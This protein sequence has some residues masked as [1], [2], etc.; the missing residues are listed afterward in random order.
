MRP[1]LPIRRIPLLRPFRPPN[2]PTLRPFTRNTLA[3]PNLPYLSDSSRRPTA[4]FLTIETKQWLKSEVKKGMKYTAYIYTFVFLGLIIT[5]GVYQET[6]ERQYHPPPEWGWYT[7]YHWKMAM[8]AEDPENETQAFVDYANTGSIYKL[9]IERLEDPNNEGA[10][11]QEQGEGGILV[12]GVGRTGFDI[13]NKSESWRRGYYGA[14]MG[15]ARA[16]EHLDDCVKDCQRMLVFPKS[17]VPGPSNP[18]PRPIPPGA[19]TPSREEDCEK[20]FEPPEI[21]YMRILTTKG[22]TEKQRVDTALAYGAWLDFKG[23]HNTALEMYKWAMEIA[24]SSS[25]STKPVIDTSIWT[26]DPNAGPPSANVLSVATAIA[27]HHALCSN[28]AL[29]LPIFISI[30]RSRRSLPDAPSN[31]EYERAPDDGDNSIA[32]TIVSLIRTIFVVPPYPPPPPD[33]TEPP[34]RTP[35]E[36][37]EEAGVMTNIG[38]IL[39]ASKS[40]KTSK[41]DGLAWTREAVDIAEEQLRTKR[42]DKDAKTTCRQCLN[43]AIGNWDAMVTRLAKEEREAKAQGGKVGGWLGFGGEEQKDM[44]GRWESEENVV[45]DRRRRSIELLEDKPAPRWTSI[46]SV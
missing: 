24:T 38:E 7:R 35:Q 22:F 41:E 10:G 43:V 21:Y 28:L 45:R 11:L 2:S 19:A 20:A 9:L 23:T 29:A 12:D 31:L 16:A 46:L 39:F 15:A 27:V 32:K 17:V 25:T 44:A 42:A 13:S 18:H 37:C 3:R 4:R 5:F 30:L 8:H 1:R 26:I 33:G 34:Q 40:S 14:L 6:F 36:L